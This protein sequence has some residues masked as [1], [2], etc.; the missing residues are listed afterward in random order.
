MSAK[1]YQTSA[2][3]CYLAMVMFVVGCSLVASAAEPA[4]AKTLE[5]YLKQQGYEGLD[6]IN[7]DHKSP[8]I[9]GSLNN[10]R[11]PQLLVDTGCGISTLSPKLARGLKTLG[12]LGTQ[13]TDPVLGRVT[14]QDIVLIDKLVLAGSATFSNQ[15]ARVK[16]LKMD[17][18]TVPFDGVLGLDF[19]LRNFCLIDCWKHRL[20]V[21][22]GQLP[23]ERAEV[24]EQSLRL[25][26]FSEVPL[27]QHGRLDVHAKINGHPTRLLIDTGAPFNLLDSSQLKDFGLILARHSSAA[28]G[29]Y[30]RRDA[31]T[32]IIGIGAIGLHHAGVTKVDSL[33]LGERKWKDVYFAATDL[34]AWGA[35]APGT[36]LENIKGFLSQEF[37]AQNGALIDISGRKLWL[38]ATKPPAASR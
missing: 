10:G 16:E 12:D 6:F 9:E 37:L 3:V 25:S 2:G 30:I 7:F 34:K 18:I 27:D 32:S 26:G 23:A 24:I 22:A 17:Y 38:R 35:A 11:K 33:D 36:R 28:T 4:E 13:L 31:D 1:I 19:L 8:L 14:N 15:P 5:G 29:S 21:R 20:Y